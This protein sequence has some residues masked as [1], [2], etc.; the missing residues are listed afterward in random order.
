MATKRQ[1]KPL[2]FFGRELEP[3]GYDMA[4]VEIGRL[5]MTVDTRGFGTRCAELSCD[6]WDAVGVYRKT[7]RGAV[8][9]CERE[10]LK[11]ARELAELTGHRLVK[12][13][14]K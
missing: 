2:T 6:G 3:V 5:D 10:T 8:A 7:P 1:P 11:L 4:G 12:K 14:G 13:G 9:A